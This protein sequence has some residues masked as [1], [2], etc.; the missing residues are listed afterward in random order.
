MPQGHDCITLISAKP[1]TTDY[2]YLAGQHIQSLPNA[3]AGD[4]AQVGFHEAQNHHEHNM[5]NSVHGQNRNTEH[6]AQ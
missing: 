5:N 4:G 1:M 6:G 3:V 2:I